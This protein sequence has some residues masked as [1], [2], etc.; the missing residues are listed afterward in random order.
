MPTYHEIMTTDLATL[1]TAA[2]GWDDMAKEFNKQEKAYK[3]DVHG[4]S[5]GQTWLGLSADAANRRFDTTL[6]EYQNAQT[7]AKAIASLLRD[8]HT[9][10]VD[11]RGKLRTARQD[12]IDADMKVSDQGVVSYDTQRLSESTRTAYRHDPDFQESVRKSVRSWQDRIDQLVKDVTDADKGVEIAFN[13]VVFDTDPQDGTFNGFNGQGRATSRSTRPRT[14]RTSPRGSREARRS[15][16]RNSPNWT[17]RSETTPRAKSSH[18][19]SSAV[20][21]LR[22]PLSS[23]TGSARSATAARTGERL[24]VFRRA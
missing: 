3:R 13:A 4:I 11:L 18:K 7:E 17:A 12:A 19:L 14:P 10:F 6:T 23:P 15:P 1:T 9:Q 24:R 8:A 22:G 21:V 16:P 20:W 2:D 5:M